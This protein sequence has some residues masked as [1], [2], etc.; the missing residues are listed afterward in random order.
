MRA[1]PAAGLTR[2]RTV[3]TSPGADRPSPGDTGLEVPLAELLEHSRA[4]A[5]AIDPAFA[6]AT[7]A[8]AR[9]MRV[10]PT[11]AWFAGRHDDAGGRG[12]PNRLELGAVQAVEQRIAALTGSALDALSAAG[13]AEP[14][15]PT[16]AELAV[17][18]T[19]RP[20]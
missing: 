13:T 4:G 7:G 11:F 16:P 9:D 3:G 8:L 5:A 20:R 1:P 12:K 18:A 10:R 6:D 17:A 2:T 14:A 15:A 19:R